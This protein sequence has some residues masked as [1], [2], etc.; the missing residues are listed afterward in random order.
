[1]SAY[2]TPAVTGA[3]IEKLPVLA[4]VGRAY[5]A[6]LANLATFFRISWFWCLVLLAV[7]A[8]SATLLPAWMASR[9]DPVEA[10]RYE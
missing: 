9:I 4:I 2:A 1:M 8:M 6:T 7:Q 3:A 5:G 10:L